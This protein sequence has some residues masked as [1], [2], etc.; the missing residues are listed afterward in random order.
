MCFLCIDSYDF[1]EQFYQED[2][3]IVPSLYMRALGHRAV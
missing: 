2:I 1:Y 3:T